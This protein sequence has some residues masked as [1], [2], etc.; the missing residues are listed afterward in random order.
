MNHPIRNSHLNFLLLLALVA[1]SGCASYWK[2]KELTAVAKDWCLTIRASQVI[3]VYPLTEDV[4]P[5]DVFL[6]QVPVAQQQ[7]A[8]K[9]KGFLPLDN[10]LTRLHPTNY[11]GF[12]GHSFLAQQ[13]NP[14]MPRDW[15]RPTGDGKPKNWE[16][17]PHT[18]FPSYSFSVKSGQGLNLAVPVQ[19]VPVGLSLLNSDAA[20][21]TVTI[22][23]ARTMGVDILSLW[24]QLEGWA[25]SHAKFL[26]PYASTDRQT[27][28]LRIITR[29]YATGR[30]DVSLRDSS[31]QNA[32]LDVGA[33][34]PVSLL[35]PQAPLGDSNVVAAAAAGY[36]NGWSLLQEMLNKGAQAK[37]A[38]GNFLPGG[39]LRL[40]GASARTVSLAEE[41]DPPVVFGYLAFDC[42]IGAAGQ[43]HPPIP[44]QAHLDAKATIHRQRA[45]DYN[46]SQKNQQDSFRIVNEYYRAANA[47]QQTAI[48]KYAQ[49]L[50]LS[51]EG[52]DTEWLMGLFEMVDGNDPIKTGKF[53]KLRDKVRELKQQSANPTTPASNP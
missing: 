17:A 53:Q 30:M 5:G 44:T 41:F 20:D 9:K 22:K 11:T 43:L 8:Y 48:R 38:A 31:S 27:N 7:D 29:V 14:L 26:A 19:G 42:A 51:A 6:V 39:S 46:S 23:Q 28:Y 35:F 2:R 1:S 15:I 18:A 10:H 52:Q 45:L 34:K 47:E 21:G 50:K 13:T 24:E 16:P 32:G 3:P 49:E 4:Q 40:T 36:T 37:D 12:Y 33:A 25:A